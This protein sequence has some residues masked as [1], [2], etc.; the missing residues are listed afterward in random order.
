MQIVLVI[1]LI[2]DT[3]KTLVQLKILLPSISLSTPFTKRFH[4]ITVKQDEAGVSHVKAFV[5]DFTGSMGYCEYKIPFYMEGVYVKTKQMVMG[6]KHHEQAEK[7]ER[8]TAV[9]VPLTK[10]KLQ[11]K[12]ADLIFMRE[13]IQTSFTRE[14]N[15]VKGKATLTLF[16][17]ADKVLREGEVLV[18][19]DDKLTTSPQRHAERTEPYSDQLLQVLTYL[20]SKF[21]LGTEFGGW[22]EIPHSGKMYRINVV[23]SKTREIY[24]TYE[25]LVGEEHVGLLSDYTT[26]FTQKCLQWD[27]LMHHN[28]A[29][30]C[31]ACGFFNDCLH[32]IR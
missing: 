32:A 22:A 17:R 10:K 19:S 25:G 3:L 26:R 12:R 9:T 31:R 27:E 29:S 6:E 8:A 13:D 20:Y 2:W 18:V 7:I 28:S 4:T 21:F 23:E 24:K 14:F 1:L 30:K 16:G 11:D 5:T 15:F